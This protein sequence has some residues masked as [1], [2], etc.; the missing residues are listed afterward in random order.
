M[1]KHTFFI[2]AFSGLISC[3]QV[4]TSGEKTITQGDDTVAN[5]DISLSKTEAL[6]DL[7]EAASQEEEKTELLFKASGAEPGWLAEIYNNKLR[8]LVDYG[9][10][11][12]IVNDSFSDVNNDKGFSYDKKVTYNNKDYTLS[13]RVF[14][15]P[16]TDIVGNQA[17]RAV[18]VKLN[19]GIYKGCGGL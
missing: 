16:C 13:V 6:G 7:I 10:D 17:N 5:V 11:S 12:V 14:N 8:L 19:D 3:T 15:K 18:V 1:I 9:K 4:N 2:L